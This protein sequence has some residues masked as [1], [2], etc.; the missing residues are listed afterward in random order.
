[1]LLCSYT[2]RICLYT[3]KTVA[4]LNDQNDRFAQSANN[5]INKM[6]YGS[7]ICLVV[8]WYGL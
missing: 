5:V 6:R 3:F 4:R 2:V 8:K 7:V 1:M